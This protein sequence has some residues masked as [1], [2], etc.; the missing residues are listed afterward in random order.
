MSKTDSSRWVV[1]LVVRGGM[2]SP[3]QKLASDRCQWISYIDHNRKKI[4][5]VF[6]VTSWKRGT[7]VRRWFN[8]IKQSVKR[9]VSQ[10]FRS[11]Q[12]RFLFDINTVDSQGWPP[13]VA[14]IMCL[15]KLARAST[16]RNQFHEYQQTEANSFHGSIVMLRARLT[17][18]PFF[19]KKKPRFSP[20]WRPPPPLLALKLSL[21][22]GCSLPIVYSYLY[23]SSRS[24]I[25]PPLAQYAVALS[26]AAAAAAAATLQCSFSV[27]YERL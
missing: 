9:V 3:L 11:H 7:D 19:V 15:D 27:S 24:S 22:P 6:F 17:S 13:W 8:H 20:V 2:V 18:H 23:R 25:L 5:W 12:V 4:H 10:C 14:W 1:Q 26:A 21:F 16:P